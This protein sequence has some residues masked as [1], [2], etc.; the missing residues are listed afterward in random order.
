MATKR[1]RGTEGTWER[2]AQTDPYWA[3]LS[4]PAKRGGG[5]NVEDFFATGEVEVASLIDYV[6]RIAPDLQRERALDFG[7]G[8][9]RVTR[10][11]GRHFKRVTGVDISPTMIEAARG[12]AWD[13]DQPTG[14]CEY[15]LNTGTKLD[16]IDDATFDLVYS[17]ITLQH[18]PPP[19]TLSYVA[20]FIRVLKPGG[21]A[22]FQLPARRRP[23]VKT[24]VSGLLPPSVR[25][26]RHSGIEMYGIP[27]GD[28]L[29]ALAMAGGEVCDV[30]RD[31][32]A[33]PQWES[34]RYAAVKR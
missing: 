14:V 15:A 2:L 32:T 17:T 31:S 29:S 27:R 23:S 24:R 12:L 8:V 1:L 7:C 25:A 13:G 33:G 28:V 19:A 5:W 9:G 10:P 18:V 21:L 6:G 22:V 16:D 34:Y 30:Q 11:L 3:I 4:E 26:K 20:E